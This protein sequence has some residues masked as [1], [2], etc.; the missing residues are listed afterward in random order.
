MNVKFCKVCGAT[1]PASEFYADP[2]AKD[3]R[4]ATCKACEQSRKKTALKLP[5]A[6]PAR[7]VSELEPLVLRQGETLPRPAWHAWVYG[8]SR[9]P[10]L[11]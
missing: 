6:S 9:N 5:Q 11:R 10:L 8:G 7:R 3:G 4:R 1:K 2:K